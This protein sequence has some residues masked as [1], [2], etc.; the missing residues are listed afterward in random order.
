[1]TRVLRSLLGFVGAVRLKQDAC[2]PFIMLAGK[3]RHNQ[4]KNCKIFCVERKRRNKDWSEKPASVPGHWTTSSW[5]GG[6]HTELWWRGCS[7]VT[8]L[9]DLRSLRIHPVHLQESLNELNSSQQQ[10]HFMGVGSELLNSQS[11][12]L[13]SHTLG[14][15][16]LNQEMVGPSPI[17]EREVRD[18]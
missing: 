16:S 17:L 9:L 7:W 6:A 2:L 14:F 4:V 8:G 5:G 13:A 12:W 18:P 1:M 15:L 11:L 3:P 10:I